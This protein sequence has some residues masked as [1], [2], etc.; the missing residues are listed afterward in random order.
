MAM[1]GRTDGAIGAATGP[2]I[3]GATGGKMVGSV[4]MLGATLGP[5]EG[6]SG[7]KLGTLGGVIC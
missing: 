3:G 4:E 6:A 7:D 5:T 1:G 2:M